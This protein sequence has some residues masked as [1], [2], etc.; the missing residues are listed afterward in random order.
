MIMKSYSVLG[1]I[2]LIL[3]LLFSLRHVRVNEPYSA[4]TIT[5]VADLVETST[6]TLFQNIEPK[7]VYDFLPLCGGYTPAPSFTCPRVHQLLFNEVVEVVQERGEEI[8]VRIPN[9]YHLYHK[10]NSSNL[11]PDIN[12]PLSK[13]NVPLNSF[14]T[15]K[16]NVLP[17]ASVGINKD[18]LLKIPPS[19][20]FTSKRTQ[21]ENVI[22]LAM[23]FT[24]P[25]TGI[26]YSAGTRFV[27]TAEQPTDK[28]LI[29]AYAFNSTTNNFKTIEIPQELCITQSHNHKER[30]RQFVS[31]IK[32]WANLDS[33]YIPYVWGGS[34]FIHT[35]NQESHEIELCVNNVE[36]SFFAIPQF[37]FTPK[38]GLDCSGIINRAA[39]IC[40][41]PF[42]LRLSSSIAT[43]LE[44][45]QP[46]EQLEGGDI[47][48]KPFHVFI[49]SD[50]EKNLIIESRGHGN[51]EGRVHE[52]ALHKVF[53]D[54]Y[55]YDDL[56]HA[57]HNKSTIYRLDKNGE[58]LSDVPEF[59]L[60]K[61]ASA[62]KI[63]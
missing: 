2:F 54:I 3:L 26:S 16:K 29:R 22:T 55:T 59:K 30:I 51:G 50:I 36:T 57:F 24:D 17:L 38:P 21:F 27:K 28:A 35:S 33:G 61:L 20:S 5:P 12:L 47:I 11:I 60:L 7:S 32:Q 25:Q 62:W 63:Y 34:S 53:K 52:I 37:D 48:W 45:L 44:E 4:L 41:I 15:L 14:W 56:V 39:Q 23:P 13:K 58:I 9:A 31:L 42:Y 18:D 40:G 6:Q 46:H 10:E 8:L 19:I 49:V 43:M 1:L